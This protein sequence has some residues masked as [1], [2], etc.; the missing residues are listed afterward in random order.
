MKKFSLLFLL[1]PLLL[2]SCMKDH[3]NDS[4]LVGVS[5][6]DVTLNSYETQKVIEAQSSFVGILARAIDVKTNQTASWLT[7][8]PGK[9]K[10]TLNLE[11]NISITDRKAKVTLYM[12]EN[13]DNVSN[14]E[15]EVVFYVTQ[16]MN[17]QFEGLKISELV[18]SSAPADSTIQ[19]GKTLQKVK[20]EVQGVEGFN[21]ANWC[22]A[23]LNNGK[24]L[25]VKVSEHKS[26]GVRQALIRLLPSNNKGEVDSLTASTAFLVTQKQNTVLDSL[27]VEKLEFAYESGS[28]VV[29]T[30][31]QLKNIKAQIIDDETF[32]NASWCTV[33][34]AGDSVTVKTTTLNV[35]KD[36][37]AK[38]TLYL[39]NNGTVIDSTTIIHTFTVVQHHNNVFD[40]MNIP[41]TTLRYDQTK[42]VLKLKVKTPMKG[43]KTKVI[44]EETSNTASWLTVKAEADSVLMTASVHKSLKDRSALVTLYY[45]NSNDVSDTSTVKT[46]YRVIQ[47]H[48]TIFDK[49]KITDVKMSSEASN[50]T[51][52][53]DKEL[54]GIKSMMVDSATNATPKWLTIK[55][56]GKKVLLSATANAG[57][58]DRKAT[59]MLYYPNNGTTID[60]NTVKT[61]FNVRQNKKEQI[62]L[63]KSSFTVSYAAQTVEL[64]VTSNVGINIKGTAINEQRIGISGYHVEGTT[65]KIILFFK[66]NKTETTYKDTLHLVSS[67]NSNVKANLYVTQ[68]TNPAITLFEGEEKAW[69]FRKDGG[70]FQLLVST[71]TPNYRV[72]KKASWISVGSKMR[73]SLGKYYH[74]ITIQN[75]TGEGPLRTDTIYVKNDEVTKKFVVS[76]D[77]YLYLSETEVKLEVGQTHQLKVTNK[78]N[79]AV[80]WK[81]G[82]ASVVSVDNTG[83]L[84]AKKRGS[85]QITV[86]IGSYKD[87][88][89]YND[90]CT[91]KVYDASDSVL[92]AR[93]YGEYEKANG[94]VTAECPITITNNYHKS[95]TLH[96]VRIVGNNGN[97]VFSP[98]NSVNNKVLNTK[99]HLD[100]KFP[101][102]TNIYQ[103]K[104][105][106]E[107]TVEGGQSFTKEIDY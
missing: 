53:F 94:Y 104:V 39:P 81:S 51:V 42:T 71:L 40:G 47:R 90:K 3:T 28:K 92:V 50:A 25:V 18:M 56:D 26:R 7:V 60:A 22:S 70:Q 24:E 63:E 2:I 96:S 19:L 33:N 79:N 29:K 73:Q 12:G 1:L 76:Q 23:R 30:D 75:Y 41:D 67:T 86:S 107:F 98:I 58:T 4:P 68:K 101:K 106:V 14:P 45:P 34:I 91:V 85:T 62:I 59:V 46:T 102:M 9:G 99:G 95:I 78:T 27:K 37:S 20:V 55:L 74:I 80:T 82:N 88:K 97:S 103:P 10:L 32:N 43:I 36:R 35:K 61:S 17:D 15:L 16:R 13:R 64:T 89:D 87:V 57:L 44:D 100:V 48:N 6:S 66:E 105:V 11:E 65:H 72:E 38:V 49:S 69:S 21:D 84:T 83:K 52:T 54:S 8:I 31:R 93:G 77:K 5:I